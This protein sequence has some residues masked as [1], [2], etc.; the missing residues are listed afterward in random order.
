MKNNPNIARDALRKEIAVAL[1]K[2]EF[3]QLNYADAFR[4]Y[5][6]VFQSHGWKLAQQLKAG[7]SVHLAD[8]VMPFIPATLTN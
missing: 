1:F 7:H 5:E 6:D 4:C 2:Q 8:A 3:P